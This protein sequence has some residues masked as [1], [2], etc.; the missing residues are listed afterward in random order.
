VGEGAAAAIQ[1][2][3][4]LDTMADK[5]LQAGQALANT[6]STPSPPA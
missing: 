2:R 1:I 4:H 3:Y 6:A 5:R